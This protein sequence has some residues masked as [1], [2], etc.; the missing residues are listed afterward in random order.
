MTKYDSRPD[1]YQH[2]LAVQKRINKCINLLLER[3]EKHDQ[4]KLQEPELTGFD[5]YTPKLSTLSFGSPEY[6]Q[7]LKE[8]ESTL[9][10]HYSVNSHH[11][12]HYPNGIRGMNLIDVLEMFCDWHA[13]TQRHQ[14][15][16]I[17]N[18][19]LINQGRFNFTDELRD[20]LQN[21]VPLLEKE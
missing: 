14:D 6:E 1:T 5:I 7:S 17:Q 13:A 15:G 8:L 21:T 9:L 12:Q 18:S 20:I 19:I 3:A 4:S 16:N 11:P 10:H 2:I